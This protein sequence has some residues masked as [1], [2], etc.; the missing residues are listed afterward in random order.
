MET[1]ARPVP[2]RVF[3]HL[4][5]SAADFGLGPP[6]ANIHCVRRDT[7]GKTGSEEKI[8]NNKNSN[9][10]W[11]ALAIAATVAAA[12]AP[13]FAQSVTMRATIPFAFSVNKGANLAP[14]N[15]IVTH[16][17]NVWTV[18]NEGTRK[19]VAI[20]NYSGLQGQT[21]EQP[22]LTFYCLATHCQLQAIHTGYG[23]LGAQVTAPQPSNSDKAE[24]GLVSVALK[25]VK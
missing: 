10:K 21:S 5:R 15:Y 12:A 19:S 4:G 22:A 2:A 8:M 16:D 13:A 24:L 6:N 25:P 14:G 1:G 7:S 17:Q 23:V 9:W 20:V 11:N 18:R 3:N